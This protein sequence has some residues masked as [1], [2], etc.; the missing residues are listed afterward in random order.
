MRLEPVKSSRLPAVWVRRNERR[1]HT[2]IPALRPQ[3]AALI[4]AALKEG[5]R[6]VIT[7][8]RRSPERQAQLYAQ[9]RTAPGPIVTWTLRSRHLTGEAF[10]VGVLDDSGTLTWPEDEEL[11][12]RIGALGEEL[13]MQWGGR[14]KGG[15]RDRP[16][17]ELPPA[18]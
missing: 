13:G 15:V 3:A 6:L 16:H 8:G 2:L 18:T 9:G 17:F 10:D 4:D 12:E 14:W 5:I 1:I 7:E 11:W